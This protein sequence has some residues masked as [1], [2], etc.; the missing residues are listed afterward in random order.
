MLLDLRHGI[1]ALRDTPGHSAVVILALALAIGAN[2]AIFSVTHAVL[3]QP[4]PFRDAERLVALWETHPI[5][6]KQEIAA[7]D[8]E[9][10]RAGTHV[11][12]DMAAFTM[13][14]DVDVSL[15]GGGVDA[16]QVQGTL[17]SH[18]LFSLLGIQPQ[19]GRAFVATD[20]Q[21]GHDRVAILGHALWQRR[22]GADP[23]VIGRSILLNG[24][25]FEVIGVLPARV[26]M[27]DWAE[28]WLPMSRFPPSARQARQLHELQ[29]VARLAPGVSIA[30]A[31]ADLQRV[32]ARLQR[33]FPVTNK[34]TGGLI[35]PLRREYVGDVQPA[36]VL[37]TMAVGLVLFI[38]CVNVVHL[39]LSRAVG[40]QRDMALRAALGATRGRLVRQVLAE[41]LVT[42]AIAGVLGVILAALSLD[43]LRHM[44][45]SLLPRAYDVQ[46]DRTTLLVALTLCGLTMVAAGLAP[47]LHA[48]RVDLVDTLKA[49]DRGSS[50]TKTRRLHAI[51]IAAEIALAL[52][53]LVSAGLTAGSF[54][55]VLAIN[56]GFEMGHVLTARIS[57]VGSRWPSEQAVQRFYEQLLAKIRA[58]P[59]VTEAAVVHTA[60]LVRS[61]SRFAVQGLP[62]PAPG[63]FP[64]AQ[65]RT[66][67]PGYFATLGQPILEGRAFDDRDVGGPRVVVNRAFVRRFLPRDRAVGQSLLSGLFSS[68][69]SELPIIG[70]AADA[71]DLGLDAVAEPTVYVCGY[72]TAENV[73]IRTALDP[74]A[75]IE[76]L[77]RAVRSLDAEQPIYDARPLDDL[78]AGRIERRRILLVLC[79][80]FGVLALILALLGVF[81]VVSRAVADRT[82]EVGVRLALGAIPRAVLFM[83]I[84]QQLVPVLTGLATGTLGAALLART[85]STLLFGIGTYDVFTY[86]TANLLV[87]TLTIIVT[88]LA[89]AQVL[90]IDPAS[91]MRHQKR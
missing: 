88:C 28:I 42:G 68:R 32:V 65:F 57:L 67:S 59:G 84:R 51:L 2:T 71:H 89:A 11:F 6:G 14:G 50:G 27:P 16:E 30:Q 4:L 13:P 86:A 23:G 15:S 48:S 69:R 46:L 83:L 3:L 79:A 55:R 63:H 9:D 72:R 77:R 80:A 25:S 35:V 31:D 61:G 76:P 81:A 43:A 21:A 17:A 36:L 5:L 19:L 22:F 56:P 24:E 34:P 7:A 53:V 38:A 40:R 78:F 70:V 12:A 41:H 85:A 87:L 91:A 64:V 33:D 37:L 1:R 75:L 20:D 73:M 10:W 90:S 39:S 60:P 58:V 44:V 82:R 47:A 52:M 29:A 49:E 66:V 62:E 74:A 18:N 8:F 45:G 26:Q 54:R